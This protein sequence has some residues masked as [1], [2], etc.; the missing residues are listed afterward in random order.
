MVVFGGGNIH[1]SFFEVI[2][3]EI[4][5]ITEDWQVAVRHREVKEVLEFRV[6]LKEDSQATEPVAAKVKNAIETR[7]PDMWRNYVKGMF[8]IDFAYAARNTLRQTRKLRRLVDERDEIR[9]DR[10]AR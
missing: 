9:G 8:D 1:P 7:Y 3:K 5:E 6:E 4:P 2:F 10:L